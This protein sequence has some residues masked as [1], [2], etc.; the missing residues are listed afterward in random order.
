M[1]RFRACG[2]LLPCSSTSGVGW[3]STAGGQS[4]CPVVTEPLS[5]GP[6]I[7]NIFKAKE[8]G[9]RGRALRSK[10]CW[11]NQ[12]QGSMRAVWGE[13]HVFFIQISKLLLLLPVKN[14]TVT[15]VQR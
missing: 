4:R 8:Q 10:T 1:M 2:K 6:F 3:R 15:S 13:K 5:K 12:L 14:L 7:Y 11:R 9:L